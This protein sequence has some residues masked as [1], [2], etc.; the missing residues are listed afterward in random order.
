MNDYNILIAIKSILELNDDFNLIDDLINNLDDLEFSKKFKQEFILKNYGASLILVE[1]YMFDKFENSFFYNK[2][3]IKFFDFDNL[4]NLTIERLK[5][6]LDIDNI[7]FNAITNSRGVKT[8]NYMYWNNKNRFAIFCDKILLSLL[9]S[10]KELNIN[11]KKELKIAKLGYYT[12]F[13]ISNPD[14]KVS[15]NNQEAHKTK[16]T[17]N[18]YNGSYA[19]DYEFLSDQFIDDVLDGDPDNYWNID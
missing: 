12:K 5:N 2:E 11:L 16:N 19:Q 10:N 13:T 3:D 17:Y 7:G 14:K 1:N 4:D 15:N 8:D 18:N 6:L 9:I